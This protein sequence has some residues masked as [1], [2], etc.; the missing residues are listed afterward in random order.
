MSLFSMSAR[1]PRVAHYAEALAAE[2]AD[3]WRGGR[4]L[5]ERRS[6]TGRRCANRRHRAPQGSEEEEA[7]VLPEV[8]EDVEEQDEETRKAT[9]KK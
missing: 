4:Q 3:Y 6:L 1:G 9:S 2:C 8:D 7:S 5:C